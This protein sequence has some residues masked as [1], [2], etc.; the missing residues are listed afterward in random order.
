[1]LSGCPAV[2]VVAVVESEVGVAPQVEDGLHVTGRRSRHCIAPPST[3]HA[4][5][6]LKPASAAAKSWLPATERSSTVPL[7]PL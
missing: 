7:I 6:E 3:L 5:A 1:M 2:D 4:A